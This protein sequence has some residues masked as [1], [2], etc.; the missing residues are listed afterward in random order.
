MANIE[1]QLQAEEIARKQLSDQ[2]ETLGQQ[3]ASTQTEVEALRNQLTSANANT[4]QQGERTA[5]LEAKVHELNAALEE[6]DTARSDKD[7][8]LAL[9]KDLLAH[10][11]DIRDLVGARDLISQI[12]LTSRRAERQQSSSAGSFIR[13]TAR[14]CSMALISTSGPVLNETYPFRREPSYDASRT[15]PA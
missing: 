15:P 11:R 7:R 9:D 10:D 14:S 5:A 6:K 1:K 12:F 3:L 8:M 2:K 13:K 4:G